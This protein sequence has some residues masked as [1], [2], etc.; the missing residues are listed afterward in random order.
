MGKRRILNMIFSGIKQYSDPYYQGVAAQLAFFFMLSTVPTILLLTQLLGFMDISLDFLDG[1][2]RKY[3]ASEM[4][5]TIEHLITSKPVTGTNIALVIMALWASSRIQFSLT[6]I[7]DYTYSGGT[8]YGHFW[9]NR[10][11]SMI[12]MVITVIIMA[13]SIVAF[14][15][16]EIIVKNLVTSIVTGKAV[17]IIIRFFIWPLAGI[18]YFLVVSFNYYVLPTVR[19]TYKKIIPGSVFVA[20]GMLVVT[21]FYDIYIRYI[22][23]YNIIYGSLAVLVAFM[24]WFYL[25][26]W[27]LCIGIFVNRVWDEDNLLEESL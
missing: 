20:V 6:R 17:E 9:R 12:T 18:L 23:N 13:M 3:I 15:S 19:Q 2:L 1:F 26:S 5:I 8:E 7:M 14:I 24:F 27:V 4:A 21:I 10:V 16:I 22:V 25:I 11:R